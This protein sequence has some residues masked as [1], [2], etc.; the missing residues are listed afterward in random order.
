MSAGPVRPRWIG[1]LLILAVVVTAC[2]LLGLWQLG[3][4]QD[5]GRAEAVAAAASL[6]REPLEQVTA[7][8]SAFEADF[9]NRP[10]SATGTYDADDQILVVDRRLDGRAGSW[11]VTPLQTPQGTVAVLRGFVDGTPARLPEP[12]AGRVTVLGTLGPGES[13]R[14]DASA[15]PE[16]QRHAIDLAAL[17]NEWP[18]RLYNVVLLASSE[19]VGGTALDPAAAGLARVPPPDLPSHLNLRSAA[20]A[21]QWWVFGLFA[22]WMFAKII[23]AEWLAQRQPVA[24]KEEAHA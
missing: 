21:I 14:T 8:H 5:R 17:V 9:S 23:R 24:P 4:A 12:P 22:I 7:P 3:V 20:Y 11:V 15:L 10:V 6:E 1:L 19:S 16:P 13:P 2:T 18:G